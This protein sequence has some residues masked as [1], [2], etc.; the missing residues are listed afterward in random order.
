MTSN[1]LLGETEVTVGNEINNLDLM[2]ASHTQVTQDHNINKYELC[3]D[4]NDI[5]QKGEFE[6]PSM[7]NDHYLEEDRLDYS[8]ECNKWE[9]GEIRNNNEHEKNR[10]LDNYVCNDIIRNNEVANI[11]L[12]LNRENTLDNLCN[13]KKDKKGEGGNK[14]DI[15]YQFDAGVKMSARELGKDNISVADKCGVDDCD[16]EL[17]EHSKAIIDM[18]NHECHMTTDTEDDIGII[19]QLE[20]KDVKV[21][22]RD[23]G[24]YV[25]FNKE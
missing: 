8:N 14:G 1:T 20:G 11:L 10:M 15:Y 16:G 2:M 4:S 18:N 24:S 25:K 6:K 19:F 17:G 5:S 9:G 22:I 12:L 23:F 13:G 3:V 21:S 7:N